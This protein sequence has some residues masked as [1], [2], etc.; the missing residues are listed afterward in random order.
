MAIKKSFIY[1]P[2]NARIFQEIRRL[3]YRHNFSVR[4]KTQIFAKI[5]NIK[6]SIGIRLHRGAR[7]CNIHNTIL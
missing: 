4:V 1:H 6:K 3:L 2:E 5:K 7:L